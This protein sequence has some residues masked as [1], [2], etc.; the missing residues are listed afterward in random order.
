[1]Q[2]GQVIWALST[3]GYLAGFFCVWVSL[4]HASPWWIF[5]W[6]LPVGFGPAVR[7]C[8][9]FA[10]TSLVFLLFALAGLVAWGEDMLLALVGVVSALWAYDLALLWMRIARAGEL[11]D[12]RHL[13]KGQAIRSGSIALG[14]LALALMFHLVDFF[15]HFWVVLGLVALVWIAVLLLLRQARR[16]Y[17]SWGS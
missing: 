6:V 11:R 14:G 8:R 3:G 9:A 7:G 4:I 15:V 2:E 13:I 5:A 12:R 17:S 1:M 10:V 16:L